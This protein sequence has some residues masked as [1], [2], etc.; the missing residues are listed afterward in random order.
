[1]VKQAKALSAVIIAEHPDTSV[2]VLAQS[3]WHHGVAGPAASQISEAYQRS[4]ILLA[5]SGELWKGS[6]RSNNGD[7]LGHWLRTVKQLGLVERGGGHAAAVGLAA[8]QAQIVPLQSAGLFLTMPQSDHEP[9]Q[10]S[11]GEIDELRP[12]EWAVVI[13]LLAPYGRRNPFPIVSA[14]RIKCVSE[15]TALASQETG[16]PWAMKT[17]FRTTG[18]K[19]LTVTWRDCDLARKQ[20]RPG[21]HFDLELELLT[22]TKGDRTFFNWSVASCRPSGQIRSDISERLAATDGFQPLPPAPTFKR[23]RR[24]AGN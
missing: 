21:A 18:S 10:E 3:G 12:E 13:E 11:I 1:M 24:K 17:S 9:E 23:R 16:E 2:I 5:P 6:G 14:I 22:Q 15:P 19:T 20:W 7:H 4:A 8:T